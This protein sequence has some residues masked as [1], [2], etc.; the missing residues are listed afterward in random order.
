MYSSAFLPVPATPSAPA[1]RLRP[2]REGDIDQLIE[3]SRDPGLRRYTSTS[4]D[5]V[6][7]GVRWVQTQESG[8][9]AGRRFSFAVVGDGPSTERVLGNVVLKE[10]ADDGATAE[11]GYW[12]AVHARGQSLAPRALDVLTE[13]AFGAFA[14]LERLVLRHQVDNVASCRVAQKCGFAFDQALV[15][16]PPRFPLEGHLHVRMNATTKT[17]TDMENPLR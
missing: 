1:L 3:L 16:G 5:S 6:A 8:W 9:V 15:P 13:W 2:W 14:A 10:F 4:V 12:T 11:V 17:S 7:D